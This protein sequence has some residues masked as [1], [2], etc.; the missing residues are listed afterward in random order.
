MNSRRP[1]LIAAVCGFMIAI[2]GLLP[3]TVMNDLKGGD[4]G[5]VRVT[6]DGSTRLYPSTR[7]EFIPEAFRADHVLGEVPFDDGLNGESRFAGDG[8]QPSYRPLVQ[9]LEEIRTAAGTSADA[10]APAEGE[11]EHAAGPAGKAADLAG[12]AAG[13][14]GEKVDSQGEP[15]LELPDP[16]EMQSH[17]G[18]EK[19]AQP[20]AASVDEGAEKSPP[21]E[22][23]ETEKSGEESPESDTF[24]NPLAAG[25]VRLL[26]PE[27]E[28]QL[29]GRG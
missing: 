16:S 21:A 25:I 17:S 23:G 19:A 10:V 13:P 6:G 4:I 28:Q 14:A 18:L 15:E 24:G 27:V 22:P 20:P 8:S 9:R 5:S 11:P 12:K 29:A 7:T 1:A 3:S 2:A 26:R